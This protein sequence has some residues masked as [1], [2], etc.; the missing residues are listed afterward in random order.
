[1]AE[2]G[3]L[4]SPTEFF[5]Q[6]Q[7]E[8]EAP[9][10]K[11]VPVAEFL[12]DAAIVDDESKEAENLS[13]EESMRRLEER[14]REKVRLDPGVMGPTQ[15]GVEDIKEG[16]VTPGL[17][18]EFDEDTFAGRDVSLTSAERRQ[19]AE[20]ME[21]L[22]GESAALGFADMMDAVNWIVGTDSS[23][24]MDKLLA[25]Q[26]GDVY[27]PNFTFR[28]ATEQSI[29]SL[30]REFGLDDELQ[31]ADDPLEIA[32][33]F[34]V[35][36]IAG[37]SIIASARKQ[38]T[39]WGNEAENWAYR[40]YQNGQLFTGKN[41]LANGAKYFDAW[42]TREAGIAA[43]GGMGASAFW[44]QGNTDE[45]RE[46][47]AN[48]GNLLFSLGGGFA[49]VTP[50]GLA[51]RTIKGTVR[52]L[53]DKGE[54]ADLWDKHDSH[55]LQ[56]LSK[57]VPEDDLPRLKARMAEVRMIQQFIPEFKPSIGNVIGTKE[58]RQVQ[59][60]IDTDNFELA[61][62]QYRSNVKAV[63]SLVKRLA[64]EADPAQREVIQTA[65]KH[66]RQEG[67]F[68][69]DRLQ[70]NVI[71]LQ[72]D[73][74]E[75]AS[76]GL[77]NDAKGK[78]LKGNLKDAQAAYRSHVDRI[79]K[80]VDPTNSMGFNISELDTTIR[81]VT[82]KGGLTDSVNSNMSGY[83]FLTEDIPNELKRLAKI[84]KEEGRDGTT[85]TY[86]QL[87]QLRIEVGKEAASI[88]A[89][90]DGSRVP[91][92]L[93][94]IINQIDETFKRTV[95]G[96]KDQGL[97]QRHKEATQFYAEKYTPLFIDGPVSQ[98]L[99]FRGKPMSP[100]K[101]GPLFWKEAADDEVS[102]LKQLRE[103]FEE[104]EL[105][106]DD[107]TVFEAAKDS[108]Y[109][110]M[111][112]FAVKDLRKQ[113]ASG[114]EAGKSPERVLAT[115][116]R[117]NEQK[118]AAF[119]TVSKFIDEL[120]VDISRESDNLTV[121]M[122]RI[123]D[124]TSNVI[125]K[126]QPRDAGSYI[127][128]LANMD[129]LQVR[130]AF[131]DLL[132]N[133][134]LSARLDPDNINIQS[135]DDIIDAIP[136]AEARREA[137]ALRE[138][139]SEGTMQMLLRN[140]LGT[141][142]KGFKPKK[143]LSSLDGLDEFIKEDAL[144]ML[145]SPRNRA[146]I[147]ILRRGTTILGDEVTP[148]SKI[149]LDSIKS[150]MNKFGTSAPSISARVYA[151]QLGKIGPVYIAVDTAQRVI[152]G[153]STLKAKQIYSKTLYDLDGL[154]AIIDIRIAAAGGDKEA[155][156]QLKDMATGL[157]GVLNKARKFISDPETYRKQLIK[158][159]NDSTFMQGEK[160][161]NYLDSRTPETEDGQLDFYLQIND[162]DTGQASRTNQAGAFDKIMGIKPGDSLTSKLTETA[163]ERIEEPQQEAT[164]EERAAVLEAEPIT[165]TFSFGGE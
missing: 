50:T 69:A 93:Q 6:P 111:E 148:K 19:Q 3:N 152:R 83:T 142:G 12:G 134:N 51:I 118:L 78:V 23:K 41:A 43:L 47:L 140:S 99:T 68:E 126:Y 79:Y 8:P 52:K 66:I 9:V 101:I 67:I 109:A 151:M 13:F 115:W 49:N 48:L 95:A 4:L 76:R 89:L 7:E 60:I 102:N 70:G 106:L 57:L 17:I 2:T 61:S 45:Q 34:G 135:L 160:L 97:S 75:R 16:Q 158:L 86:T 92:K 94:D 98:V 107:P 121:H 39:K 15:L 114:L 28:K 149:E 53:R 18:D 120:G 21:R 62:A 123:E 35:E 96:E 5:G 129:G 100:D 1:M 11:L 157:R 105:K 124:I 32:L 133:S 132:V 141:D 138:A 91:A 31:I 26:N 156:K 56:N 127:K 153:V 42:L 81:A 59:A 73:L 162:K 55:I 64:E 147:N 44:A 159:M 145:L 130:Q 74:L 136:V 117:T 65:M 10:G 110:I 37:L 71:R 150:F 46:Q 116:R 84:A 20:A 128:E 161:Q 36:N 72:S 113:I 77:D 82:V 155:V 165:Q 144:M 27:D 163:V 125:E 112:D 119:P 90:E 104:N 54:I 80:E 40:Q 63:D 108:V 131:N 38:I 87:Q 30:Y 103:I 33:R 122:D 88:R 14:E 164:E 139:I 146:E 22:L 24:E 137:V 143:L 154:E 29:Q 25:E 58:A 85:L